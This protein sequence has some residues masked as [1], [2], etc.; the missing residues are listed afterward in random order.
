MT[1]KKPSPEELT[2]YYQLGDAAAKLIC[3]IPSHNRTSTLFF[4]DFN[5]EDYTP[6]DQFYRNLD[7]GR[8]NTITTTINSL[9][10]KWVDKYDRGMQILDLA[11]SEEVISLIES[12][13][14]R[15]V[16]PKRTAFLESLSLG[17][18]QLTGKRIDDLWTYE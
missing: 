1:S 3:S 12:M 9:S 17:L 10:R 7:T 15:N 2:L 18:S 5:S 6:W 16:G 4:R 13:S 14:L 11:D 8:R